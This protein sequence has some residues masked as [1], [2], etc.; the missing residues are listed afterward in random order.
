MVAFSEQLR[1]N[2]DLS[3]EV[4]PTPET[5]ASSIEIGSL[6][7]GATVSVEHNLVPISRGP[8]GGCGFWYIG[9]SLYNAMQ[10]DEN[11]SH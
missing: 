1:N 5:G 2:P 7:V 3:L 9:D 8:V 4:M 10:S 11:Q 6:S